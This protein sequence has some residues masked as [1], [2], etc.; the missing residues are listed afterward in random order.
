PT[1]SAPPIHSL[2]FSRALASASR[3]MPAKVPAKPFTI[4]TKSSNILFSDCIEQSP[5]RRGNRELDRVPPP[6]RR[7]LSPSP[8]AFP[9]FLRTEKEFDIA[10]GTGDRARGDA[11]HRPA[12]LG[13]PV[14][15]LLADALVHGRIADDPALAD[16]L[17]PRLELRLDQRH[18]P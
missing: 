12:L 14:R 10:F 4:F 11:K 5:F 6:R 8:S 16:L 3:P 7:N 1:K 9:S 15:G 2:N 18:Q 17:A 13:D